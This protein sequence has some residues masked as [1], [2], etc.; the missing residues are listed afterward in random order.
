MLI[1]SVQSYITYKNIVSI[2]KAL[3]I[4]Y[5]LINVT[6]NSLSDISSK[7]LL[8][9]IFILFELICKGNRSFTVL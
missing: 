9:I 8:I 4:G 3:L 5:K 1:R 6:T 7:A 2:S